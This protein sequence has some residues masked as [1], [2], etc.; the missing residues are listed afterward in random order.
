MNESRG[1]NDCGICHITHS[2]D[3]HVSELVRSMKSDKHFPN[4][5][6]MESSF[7]IEAFQGFYPVL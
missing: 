2:Q 3:K 7:S 6:G 5:L 4:G 1:K